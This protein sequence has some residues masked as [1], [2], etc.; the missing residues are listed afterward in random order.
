MK[1]EYERIKTV[2]RSKGHEC[3]CN[4][5]DCEC[6]VSTLSDACSNLGALVRQLL[7]AEHEATEAS[8]R[9]DTGE[10]D[11]ETAMAARG[12]ALSL[13]LILADVVGYEWPPED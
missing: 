9:F 6:A 13:H 5:C 3:D 12:R 1:L 2:L 10:S 4:A 8:H 11:F 7:T